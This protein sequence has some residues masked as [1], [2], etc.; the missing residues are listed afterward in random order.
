MKKTTIIAVA[1]AVL[2]CPGSDL[3]QQIHP[4]W[5]IQPSVSAIDPDVD[6]GVDERD[7]GAGLKFGNP[8]SQNWDVQ[9]GVTHARTR[10]GAAKYRQTLAGADALLMISRSH[11]RPFLLFG[12]GAE[13][14]MSTIRRAGCARARLT[15][16]PAWV[17][18]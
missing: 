18:R 3:A 8:L 6:F 9:V 13:P 5:Y 15:P 11:V 4:S 2:V 7:W 1:S 10:T 14:T 17:F 12:L 16:A